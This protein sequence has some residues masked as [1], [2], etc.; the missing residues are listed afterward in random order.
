MLTDYSIAYSL[1]FV[2]GVAN[3]FSCF[4]FSPHARGDNGQRAGAT[5]SWLPFCISSHCSRI[6]AASLVVLTGRG[7]DGERCPPLAAPQGQGFD[8]ERLPSAGRPGLSRGGNVKTAVFLLQSAAESCIIE[9][10]NAAPGGA[11]QK[12]KPK[13]NRNE[14]LP[15]D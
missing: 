11:G 5:L 15:P 4:F 12:T 14:Y 3:I 6:R 7:F 10:N 9:E 1:P 13:G 8:G 2:K